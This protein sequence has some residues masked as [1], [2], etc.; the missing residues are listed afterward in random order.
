[1]LLLMQITLNTLVWQKRFSISII[2][3][4]MGWTPPCFLTLITVFC[5]SLALTHDLFQKLIFNK[6]YFLDEDFI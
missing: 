6:I 5:L 1:M 3:L 2:A 4:S